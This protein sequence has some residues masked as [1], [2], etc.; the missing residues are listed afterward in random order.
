MITEKDNTNGDISQEEINSNEN[1]NSNLSDY[2]T[3]T[4]NQDQR[5]DNQN[6][7]KGP[8]REQVE[9][10]GESSKNVIVFFFKEF[11]SLIIYF[12]DYFKNK[13]K[14]KSDE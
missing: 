10:V 1:E 13:P 9:N 3:K 14:N 6:E 12:I 5:T 2:S 4:N 7:K 8:I 11:Y